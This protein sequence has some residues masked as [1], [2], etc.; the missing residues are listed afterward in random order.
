VEGTSSTERESSTSSSEGEE[1]SAEGIVEL[2]GNGSAFL[3][4]DPPEPS[5]E[6]VYIS[7]AS[8]SPATG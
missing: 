4:V 5:D 2:L 8:S 7:A 3:R 6:D 1:R